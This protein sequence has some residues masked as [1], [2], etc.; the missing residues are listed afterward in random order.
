M[1]L[2]GV[3]FRPQPC[4]ALVRHGSVSYVCLIGRSS[5][6]AFVPLGNQHPSPEYWGMVQGFIGN[7]SLLRQWQVLDQSDFHSDCDCSGY[8]GIGESP[9]EVPSFRA[10]KSPCMV[11]LDTAPQPIEVIRA[12]VPVVTGTSNL[13]SPFAMDFSMADGPPAY[14]N[15]NYVHC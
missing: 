9:V 6:P 15:E 13:G 14:H 7:L 11:R 10:V 3:L 5:W 8:G 1:G 12:K 4:F 2:H